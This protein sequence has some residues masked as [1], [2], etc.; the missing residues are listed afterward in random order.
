MLVVS[1]SLSLGKVS[2]HDCVSGFGVGQSASLRVC[3]WV[4]E[5]TVSA[6]VRVCVGICEWRV[7]AVF[8]S[9]YWTSLNIAFYSVSH[10]IR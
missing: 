9:V 7:L 5:C 4:R 3:V 1:L 10:S 6:L 2:Q 8:A